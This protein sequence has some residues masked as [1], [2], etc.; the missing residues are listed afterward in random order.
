[1][2]TNFSLKK[3]LSLGFSLISLLS[4]AVCGV[5]SYYF[6]GSLIQRLTVK[7]LNDQIMGVDSAIQV[8]FDENQEH[9]TKLMDYWGVKV[10]AMARL[11][12][13]KTQNKIIENQIT[14]EKITL[15]IPTLTLDGKDIDSH[16]FVDRVASEVGTATTLF[17]NI[18]DK[19][20]VRASTSIR[21]KEGARNI[22]TL[23]PTTSEVYQAVS[24]GKRYVGR[25]LVVGQWYVTAYEPLVKEGKLIGAFFMGIPETSSLRIKSYLKE[26]KI[27]QSGYFYILDSK[28]NFL[29][30]PNK[31]CH[32]FLG[33]K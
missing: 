24:D 32:S 3:K 14:H 8:S 12:L 27:L 15:P 6:T 20:L 13:A 10:S 16:D 7:S 21:N 26:Q 4:L 30:H 1:M 33:Y 23:I 5:A 18:P 17:I 29:L 28:G 19:G 9:Q 25:A 22:N 2:N 31:E 11:D